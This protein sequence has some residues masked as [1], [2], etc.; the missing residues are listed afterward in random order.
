[1]KR[2]GPGEVGQRQPSSHP[3]TNHGRQCHL[4]PKGG[5]ASSENESL[6]LGLKT[7]MSAPLLPLMTLETL[8]YSH[9]FSEFPF[10]E[11]WEQYCHPCGFPWPSRQSPKHLKIF[12][13]SSRPL[14]HSPILL[15]GLSSSNS[16]L[17]QIELLAVPQ[18]D[19]GLT[20]ETF[21][22]IF[23]AWN[24]LHSS[25]LDTSF[26]FQVSMRSPSLSCQ[27]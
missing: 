25:L 15:S 3:V 12:T 14:L 5:H 20:S 23:S 2:E 22:L 27:Y 1:M 6:I 7:W 11:K 13:K 9:H 21:P 8:D 24:V 10:A 17:Q 16:V 18:R 4:L 19:Q 26:R